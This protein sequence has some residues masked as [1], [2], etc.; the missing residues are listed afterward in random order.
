MGL[1]VTA[2]ISPAPTTATSRPPEVEEPL[3]TYIVHPM[4]RGLVQLLVPTGISPNLVSVMGVVMMASAAACYALLAWPW[5]ALIGILFH[6]AWH[7]FDGADGELA[8]RTGRA[9]PDGEIVDGICDHLSHVILYVVMGAILAERMGPWGWPIAVGAGL[10]RALH[11]NAY[12]TVRRNYRRWV[13]DVRWIRQNV[14]QAAPPPSSSPWRRVGHSL[15][16]LY[17]KTS[18]VMSANDGAVEAVMLRLLET[19]KAAQAR[20]L[21]RESQEPMVN[22]ASWL[23]TNY[24]TVA[25]A[26]SILIGSPIWFLLNELTVLNLVMFTTIRAQAK[27]YRGLVARLEELER[28]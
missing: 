17:L 25:A 8:R 15:A 1:K 3:N 18:Q 23:S 7:V 12:E 26:L 20:A 14:G 2:A 28:A 24:E 16:Q 11:A 4:A 22:C 6:T 27:S 13:Y 21:Y 5:S 9:S 10:S 19:G